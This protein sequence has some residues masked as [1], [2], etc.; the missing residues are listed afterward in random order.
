M[1]TLIFEEFDG[2]MNPKSVV[3]DKTFVWVRV[4]KLVVAEHVIKVMCKPMGEIKEVACR[5]RW[6]IGASNN[7]DRCQSKK[8]QST[9]RR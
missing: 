7:H 6:R 1:K 4:L 8:N 2:F 3:L 5:F 9:R